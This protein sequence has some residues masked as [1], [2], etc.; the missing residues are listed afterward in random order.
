M[1]SFFILVFLNKAE[2]TVELQVEKETHG[3]LSIQVNELS[4]NCAVIESEYDVNMI[5]YFVYWLKK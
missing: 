5:F 3:N 4:K 2:R 1:N